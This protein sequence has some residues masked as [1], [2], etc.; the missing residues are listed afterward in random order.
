VV[1]S[2]LLFNYGLS[3]DYINWFYSYLTN[4]PCY[5]R[6]S[7]GFSSPFVALSG[8]PQGSV[9]G[10]LLFNTC[11]NNVSSKIKHCG[12]LLFCEDKNNFHRITYIDVSLLSQ[13]DSNFAQNCCTAVLLTHDAQCRKSKAISFS[14]KI[15]M[16][17]FNHRL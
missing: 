10:P 6:F 15:N 5:V 1:F 8:V 3:A 16:L 14:G 11:I 2:P 17:T 4:S 12:F 13:S 7:G 9:L